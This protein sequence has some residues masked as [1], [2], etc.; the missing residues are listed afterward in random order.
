[1]DPREVCTGE[2]FAVHEVEYEGKAGAAE[3]V[4]VVADFLVLLEMYQETNCDVRH[5]LTSSLTV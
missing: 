4:G 3:E 5:T 2:V 1:V